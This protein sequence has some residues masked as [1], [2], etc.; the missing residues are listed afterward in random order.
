ML[1]PEIMELLRKASIE[2]DTNR[3]LH[4]VSEVNRLIAVRR[5]QPASICERAAEY[6]V[7][8]S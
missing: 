1:T 5:K 4:L 3:L 7:S 6:Q 8:N 2:H